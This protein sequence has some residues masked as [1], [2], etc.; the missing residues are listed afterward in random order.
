[1]K[2]VFITAVMV[3]VSTSCSTLKKTITYSSFSGAM[4]GAS[5]GYLLSPDKESRGINAAIFGLVGA[6]IAA[7]A[8]YSF[9]EDDP[10]NKKLN[11]MLD[12][13][14]VLGEN[15]VGLDLDDLKI[16]AKLNKEEAYETPVKDLP[17]ELKGKVKKQYV[18]KYQSKERYINKGNKTFY[19]PSFQIYEHSYEDLKGEESE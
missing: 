12:E 1:M 19:I 7:L 17:K 5:A 10:R 14:E 16:E 2:R 8:G 9:Y 18:I 13:K 6:G 11:H 15:T 3:I 4:A